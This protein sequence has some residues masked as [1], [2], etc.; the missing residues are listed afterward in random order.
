MAVLPLTPHRRC[1]R[2]SVVGAMAGTRL[3]ARPKGSKRVIS[4]GEIGL[5]YD[6]PLLGTL[7][8]QSD[9]AE[10]HYTGLALLRRSLGNDISSHTQARAGWR[11]SMVHLRGE[12]F[13]CRPFVGI[14]VLHLL[15][16]VETI[17]Q[18]SLNNISVSALR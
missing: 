8:G 16:S 7:L 13:V 1:C 4:L 3:Q 12:R 15:D 10:A 14:A 6:R 18:G 17:C 5:D 9:S 11:G 2:L